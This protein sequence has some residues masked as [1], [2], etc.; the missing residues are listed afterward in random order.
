MGG[1]I[2][3]AGRAMSA[4]N[5]PVLLEASH[6]VDFGHIIVRKT[7]N[8]VDTAITLNLAEDL[9]ITGGAS[10]VGLDDIPFGDGVGGPSVD[11]KSIVAGSREVT[12]PCNR[13]M[14]HELA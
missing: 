14:D 10:A 5:G 11:G 3:R 12:V 6:P 1:D 2:D 8:V 7:V 13:A 4:S 9:S